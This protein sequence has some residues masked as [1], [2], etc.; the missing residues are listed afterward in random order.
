MLSVLLVAGGGALGAAARFGTV[1]I[2]QLLCGSRFPYGTLIVN[3]LGAFFIGFLMNF[4][5]DRYAENAEAWRFFLVV[6]F[7]GGF[8]TFSSFAWET[9]LL[10]NNGNRLAAALN[11]LGNNMGTLILVLLGVHVS[12]LLGGTYA[13]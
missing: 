8:T 5:M 1:N 7:L 4:L 6:G 3:C 10:L 11:I 9:L 12:R 2:A 13:G